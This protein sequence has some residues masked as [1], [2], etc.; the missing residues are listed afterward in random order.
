MLYRRFGFLQAR[1]LLHKQDELRR[2]ETLLDGIDKY[3]AN[4]RPNLLKARERD[5]K[6]SG[7]RKKLFDEI[8]QKFREY[9][10]TPHAV[11][12]IEITVPLCPEAQHARTIK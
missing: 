10:L 9:G 4:N 3:D 6:E 2:M 12:S 7:H 1:L 5:D 11:T 8:E